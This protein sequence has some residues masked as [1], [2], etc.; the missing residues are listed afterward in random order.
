VGNCFKVDAKSTL[1]LRDHR[2]SI[3]LKTWNWSKTEYFY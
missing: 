2:F 1:A 3:K